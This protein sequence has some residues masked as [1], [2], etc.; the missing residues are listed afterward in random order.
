MHFGE[1]DERVAARRKLGRTLQ[2][3]HG[4][5]ELAGRDPAVRELLV[6]LVVERHG[7]VLDRGFEHR[8]SPVRYAV[9]HEQIGEPA[10]VRVL[11]L[12][13]EGT[14]TPIDFVYRVLFPFARVRMKE[15]LRLHWPE[16]HLQNDLAQLREEQA[17]DSKQGLNPPEL[18]ADSN[19]DSV[20]NY[21]FWLMDRD[22]KS[23]ALKD[24]QGLIWEDGY[25]A[26]ELRG[27]VWDDV[28]RALS[29][30]QKMGLSIAIY[31]SGSEL[32]QRRLFE[33]AAQGDMTRHIA[34]FFD[35]RVGSKLESQSYRRIADM[36]RVSPRDVCFVSDV[37]AELRAAREA[38]CAVV[39]SA[40]PGNP[41]QQ[42]RHAFHTI[43][44]L[45]E[46]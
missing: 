26:G 12:D 34:A 11:L 39:L 23:P 36:L 13:I 16:D 22:R 30:W 19:A 33:S 42:D 45:D 25:R 10:D 29:R 46:L 6:E 17:A 28:P 41:P 7:I 20:A 18:T 1:A 8:R 24:L 43:S 38:G 31:S 9:E 2:R 27:V 4:L 40:R 5:V 21:I 15:Y 3:G 37:T 35:T 32:A 44:T 14:T